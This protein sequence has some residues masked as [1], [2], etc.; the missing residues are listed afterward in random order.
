MISSSAP[1]PMSVSMFAPMRRLCLALVASAV[2][3]SAASFANAETEVPAQLTQDTVWTKE[4]S[5]YRISGFVTV[6]PGVNLLL[7]PGVVVLFANRAHLEVLQ[8]TMSIAG[9]VAEP[10]LLTGSATSSWAL[11][12]IGPTASSTKSLLAS[13]VRFENASQGIYLQSAEAIVDEAE[14]VGGQ[15]GVYISSSTLTLSNSRLSGMSDSGI[16]ADSNSRLTMRNVHMDRLGRGSAVGIY[17]SAADIEQSSFTNGQTSAIEVYGDAQRGESQV[18][19]HRSVLTGF[20]DEA[21]YNGGQSVVSAERNW[22]GSKAGPQ[23]ATYGQVST[24]PWLMRPPGEQ[25][26]SSVIFIPGIQA[27]RLVKGGNQLWEPNRNADVEKLYLD[28]A[29]KVLVD[30]V[31]PTEIIDSV[32]SAGAGPN[33]YKSFMEMLDSSVVQKKMHE[34]LPFPYD[35][36]FSASAAASDAAIERLLGVASSSFTG[37]VS[38]V[39]H[40]NGGLVARHLLNRLAER[41]LDIVDKVIFVAVPQLGTPQAIA[42][43]L[44]GDGLQFAGGLILKQSVGRRLAQYSPGALGLLPTQEY[45]DATLSPIVRFSSTTDLVS[46]NFF[47]AYG[48]RLDSA[49]RLADFLA[50]AIDKRT[51]PALANIDIPAVIDRALLT[52][53]VPQFG[54]QYPPAEVSVIAGWGLDT[55]S[56]VEYSGRRRCTSRVISK[57]VFSLCEL[58]TSLQRDPVWT[59]LGDKTVVLASALGTPAPLAPATDQTY[60]VDLSGYND[61]R[62][63]VS[64]SHADILEVPQM[65]RLLESIL[66]IPSESDESTSLLP[67]YVATSSPKSADLPKQIRLSVH[68]P[69]TL[70]LYDGAGNHTGLTDDSATSS[71]VI[72]YEES[73]PGSQYSHFGEAKYLSFTEPLPLATGYLATTSRTIQIRSVGAGLVTIDVEYVDGDAVTDKVSFSDIPVTPFTN[74][75]AEVTLPLD[76]FAMLANAFFLQTSAATSTTASTTTAT[77]RRLVP[78]ESFDPVG[79]LSSVRQVIREICMSQRLRLELLARLNTYISLFERGELP[80]AQA[81]LK[82]MVIVS[83]PE[84]TLLLDT[85]GERGSYIAAVEA[86]LSRIGTLSG[87]R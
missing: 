56:A 76:S 34:W 41:Q 67:E 64:R 68:S 5:P 20:G 55:L 10:V 58:R 16:S 11:D 33:I 75:S 9:T 43:V 71:P 13:H 32:N 14:F 2:F 80:V 42:S 39:A 17:N 29:G 53:S 85:S 25:G 74:I 50:A 52:S 63:R 23:G 72:S 30:D 46:M 47:Q 37:K 6:R 26:D 31:R 86:M 66:Y 18:S 22:W 79:Y 27:T 4:G 28:S 81:Q 77:P 57:Q 8:G 51:P 69:V 40:S 7:E 60:F 70:D 84:V 65:H 45:F 15:E 49:P 38:I 48:D 36:R 1:S 3:L 19:I 83:D 82:E 87:G 24:T 54:N 62:F 59:R 44:H 73:V 35:W 12:V 21:V 78:D 61:Q